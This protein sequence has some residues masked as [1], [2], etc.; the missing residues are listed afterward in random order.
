MRCARPAARYMKPG[1]P[2]YCASASQS[3]QTDRC[4]P[5][6]RLVYP[7][8]QAQKEHMH[9]RDTPVPTHRPALHAWHGVVPGLRSRVHADSAMLAEACKQTPEHHRLMWRSGSE[10]VQRLADTLRSTQKTVGFHLAQNPHPRS[11]AITLHATL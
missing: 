3:S 8:K 10:A 6:N 4:K 11:Y 9:T 2:Q 7:R 1:G 5:D